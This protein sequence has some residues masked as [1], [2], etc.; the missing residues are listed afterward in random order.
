MDLNNCFSISD[1][2]LYEI[3]EIKYE[4]NG[5]KKLIR[6]VDVL[7]KKN[8]KENQILFYIY[9]DGTVKKKINYHDN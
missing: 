9:D 4:N 3:L 5:E 6:I 8:R 7:G 2:I 1:P